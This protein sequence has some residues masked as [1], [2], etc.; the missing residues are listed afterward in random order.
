MNISEIPLS[1]DNQNFA[2]TIA[3]T[4]YRMR[5][6]WRDA[7]WCLDLLN[8]DQTSIALSLPLLAG[9]DLLAPYAYLNLGFSMFVNSD[10]EGQE[11]PTKTDLG[12]YSH[13]YVVTE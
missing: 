6:V 1:A 4:A 10:T 3:G 13:L 12:I 2:I 8:G 11:N 7:F 9:A 5:L